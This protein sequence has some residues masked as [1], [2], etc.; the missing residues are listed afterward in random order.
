M[1]YQTCSLL[2][3]LLRIYSKELIGS[4]PGLVSFSFDEGPSK[5]TSTVLN[6][7]KNLEISAMFHI[8][9]D[10]LP[11]S[12]ISDRIISEGHLLGLSISENVVDSSIDEFERLVKRKAD[13]FILK[14]GYIPKLIRLPRIGYTSE[15]VEIAEKLGFIVTKPSLDSEDID[16]ENFLVPFVMFVRRS[17]PEAQSLGIVFRDRM[18][19]V[20]LNLTDVVEYLSNKGFSIVSP[21]VF[22]KIDGINLKATVN[23]IQS[24]FDRKKSY[25]IAVSN[26]IDKNGE[27]I[28]EVGEI[29]EDNTI[30]IT[31]TQEKNKVDAESK[32]SD[33]LVKNDSEKSFNQHSEKKKQEADQILNAES[34]KINEKKSEKTGL[35][36]SEK[37][38]LGKTINEEEIA[39]KTN[40]SEKIISEE[41]KKSQ[42]SAKKFTEESVDKE[43]KLSSEEITQEHEQKKQDKQPI[44]IKKLNFNQIDEEPVDSAAIRQKELVAKLRSL[45]NNETMEKQSK[46]SD[47][48]NT[49]DNSDDDAD[50]ED[51]E[52][53]KSKKQNKK[54]IKNE[55]KNS[56]IEKKLE[57]DEKKVSKDLKKLSKS[58]A[59]SI[60]LY[61]V[62]PFVCALACY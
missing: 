43:N 47:T 48:R 39:E 62:V 11:N 18:S 51:E 6:I 46:D 26:E 34:G 5:H 30:N 23:E 59:T 35:E 57:K 41:S 27:K 10:L 40:F 58:G 21:N 16:I 12:D 37:N 33:S 55:K 24:V 54:D 20:H 36:T 22:Y 32:G 60:S 31:N 38:D 4:N 14:T 61:W 49:N 8:N 1:L 9:P 19:S 2:M 50:N 44:W 56:K 3:F 15:H 42:E 29:K 45:I 25:E 13:D 52:N 17:N 28:A 53:N 7:L